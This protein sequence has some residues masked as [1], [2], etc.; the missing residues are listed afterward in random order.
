MNLLL[1][2][3]VFLW[4]ISGDRQ[5][6]DKIVRSINDITNRCYISIATIWEI[7]IKLSI[8]KLELKGGFN[9]I[10]EF[11]LNNDF[12]ILPID[13]DDTKKLLSLEYHHR[14][15]FDRMI[16][17]Q[18]QTSNAVVVTKDKLFEKYDIKVLW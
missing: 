15:P 8:D 13:F 16:I 10:E 7:V 11:L 9:T 14:D 6:P 2:T 3:H 17:A 1:D 5:L 18:A 4:Y 12:E